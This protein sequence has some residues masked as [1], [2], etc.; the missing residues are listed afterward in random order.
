LVWLRLFHYSWW[1]RVP[2]AEL[3]RC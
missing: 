2:A 1:W 3:R